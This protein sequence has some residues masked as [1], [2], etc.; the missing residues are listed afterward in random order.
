MAQTVQNRYK[1]FDISFKKATSGDVLTIKD[2]EAVKRSVKLLVLTQFGERPFRPTIG[3]SVYSS[4][5][6]NATE[7]T[8]LTIQQSVKDV[9]NNFEPRARL[10]KVDV[11]FD[12]IDNNSIGIDIHF[13][14]VNIPEPVT[15]K[16]NLE[17]VR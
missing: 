14:V 7:F 8:K 2:I 11:N 10:I 12:N 1:D 5:F 13:Y 16:V 3:S 4:L 6:E 9:L 17:R 15:V